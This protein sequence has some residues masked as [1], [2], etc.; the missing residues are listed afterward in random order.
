[1]DLVLLDAR[2]R[3]G[4]PSTG[5]LWVERRPHRTGEGPTPRPLTVTLFR[6]SAVVDVVRKDE[7]ALEQ[8]E[9]ACQSLSRV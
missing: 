2:L 5:V 8:C 4:F 7:L 9:S 1:M 6:N 3:P